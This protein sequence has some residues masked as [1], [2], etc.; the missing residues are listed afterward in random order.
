MEWGYHFC[1]GVTPLPRSALRRALAALSA[2]L[3]PTPKVILRAGCQILWND[4][5]AFIEDRYRHL[6][7]GHTDRGLVRRQST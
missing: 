3:P 4:L 2:L 1:F 7:A 5:A 6:I